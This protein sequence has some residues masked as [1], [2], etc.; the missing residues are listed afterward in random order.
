MV[1]LKAQGQGHP[2]RAAE[3]LR[4]PVV[5]HFLRVLCFLR[6]WGWPKAWGIRPRARWF[7]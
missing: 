2:M 4:W 1:R 5:L 3:R 7:R 6:G